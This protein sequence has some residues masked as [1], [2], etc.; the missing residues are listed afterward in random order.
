MKLLPEWAPQRATVLVWPHHF[1]DWRSMLADIEPVYQALSAAIS[2][3]QR[4]VLVGYDAEHVDHIRKQCRAAAVNL[5]NVDFCE[6]RTNDTWVRDYGPISVQTDTGPLALDFQFNGWGGK[7]EAALDNAFTAQLAQQ[8]ALAPTQARAKFILEGGSIEVNGAGA[9]LT[10]RACLLTETRNPELNVVEI[11]QQLMASLG[12]E[13]VHW[14]SSGYLEGD[15]TDSHIDMLARFCSPRVICYTACEDRDDP[16]F[17]ALQ[18]MAEELV[19]LKAAD[20]KAYDCQPLPW[21][22]PVYDRVGN[23]LPASYGNFLVINEA[24][25]V[26]TYRNRADEAALSLLSDCFPGRELIPIDALPLIHQGGSI[27]CASMQI[28]RFSED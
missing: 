23:R 27:H 22:S 4:L 15:D 12:V 18:R 19:S 9:L 6:I 28:P 16:H 11:E 21:P 8:W 17:P 1:S 3:R 13:T 2:E 10:T 7:F 24:V 26:P 25:L 20:G 5:A 14:L